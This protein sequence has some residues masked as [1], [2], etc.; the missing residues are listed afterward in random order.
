MSKSDL[1]ISIS[2][3]IFDKENN[4]VNRLG[5]L[6]GFEE[7]RARGALNLLLRD[8]RNEFRELAN[9]IGIPLTSEDWEVIV[10]RFCLDFYEC[11]NIW[12]SS[13]SP[14]PNQTQ[15]CMTIMRSVARGKKTISEISHIQNIAFNLCKEF[16]NIYGR[17]K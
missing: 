6:V 14:N 10:L 3:F 1:I 11:F 7:K 13:V 9:S 12:S 16:E 8:R 2:F 5:L 15:K 4:S 17:I